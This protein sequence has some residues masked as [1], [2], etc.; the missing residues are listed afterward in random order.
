LIASTIDVEA[1][2]AAERSIEEKSLSVAAR[3]KALAD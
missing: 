1:M 2:N 3:R